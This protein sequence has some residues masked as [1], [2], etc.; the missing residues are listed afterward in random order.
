MASGVKVYLLN[1]G[2]DPD[3]YDEDDALLDQEAMEHL[4]ARLSGIGVRRGGNVMYWTN[5][6]RWAAW[7]LLKA[8]EDLRQV[9]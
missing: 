8:V 6:D 1:V 4:E 7:W 2:N 3:A 5:M 9:E